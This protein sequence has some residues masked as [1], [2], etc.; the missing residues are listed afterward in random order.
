MITQFPYR[1]PNKTIDIFQDYFRTS[2]IQFQNENAPNTENDMTRKLWLVV[3]I[4]MWQAQKK[5]QQNL[6]IDFFIRFHV[7]SKHFSS[8]WKCKK[9]W[10]WEVSASQTRHQVKL[11]C[12]RH[13]AI[14]LQAMLYSLYQA[15]GLVQDHRSRGRS[16][17]ILKFLRNCGALYTTFSI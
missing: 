17:R 16:C 15:N 9:E 8:K 3:T 10:K 12:F 7:F 4:S 2:C 5:G 1:Q 14:V 11:R 13:V 6:K